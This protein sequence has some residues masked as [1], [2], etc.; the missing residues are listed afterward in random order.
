[1]PP[2]RE[3]TG[4]DAEIAALYALEPEEFTTAREALVRDLRLRGDRAAAERVH[5]L[6]RP[7]PALWAVNGLARRR[8]DAVSEL[9]RAAEALRSAQGRLLAGEPGA[10]LNRSAQVHRDAVSDLAELGRELLEEAGR[11]AS[12]AMVE[13]I[14]RTLHSA[15]LLEEA[16]PLLAQ[17]RLTGEVPAHGFGIEGMRPDRPAE[18]RRRRADEALEADARRRE[19]HAEELRTAQRALAEA[20]DTRDRAMGEVRT[21]VD[22]VERLGAAEAQAERALADA[23][24]QVVEAGRALA[25]AEDAEERASTEVRLAAERTESARASEQDARA[26]LGRAQGAVEEARARLRES[27]GP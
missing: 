25:E 15:S 2:G 7:S 13:R 6:R 4:T 1:M 14:R 10:E 19:R 16:R 26:A 5:A 24:R 11:P 23:R 3:A 9:L 21:A 18:P 22:E 17:G 12:P 27:H 8:P 20:E